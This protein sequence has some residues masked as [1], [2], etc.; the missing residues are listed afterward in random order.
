LIIMER[1][2]ANLHVKIALKKA[3]QGD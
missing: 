1:N 3:Q 2:I